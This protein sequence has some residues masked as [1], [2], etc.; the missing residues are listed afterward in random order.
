MSAAPRAED[1][2]RPVEADK[3]QQALDEASRLPRGQAERYFHCQARLYGGIA[4]GLLAA[5]PACR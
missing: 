3:M 5:A 4:V 1:G 2:R